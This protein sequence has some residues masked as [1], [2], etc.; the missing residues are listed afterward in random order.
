MLRACLIETDRVVRL[1]RS[2]SQCCRRR[3]VSSC[4]STP[5][6][7]PR[8]STCTYQTD[9]ESQTRS[10]RDHHDT[11]STSAGLA[12]RDTWRP[13]EALRWAVHV[14]RGMLPT[15]VCWEPQSTT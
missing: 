3:V 9:Q 1:A 7:R 10:S 2:S 5:S 14:G 11:D 4:T 15:S 12:T 13:R 8:R 6:L